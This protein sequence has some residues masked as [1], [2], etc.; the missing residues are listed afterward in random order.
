LNNYFH[1]YDILG[2]DGQIY[3]LEGVQ[4]EDHTSGKATRVSKDGIE[5]DAAEFT[6]SPGKGPKVNQL[7]STSD[8]FRVSQKPLPATATY[9]AAV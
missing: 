9:N 6:I 7:Q 3:N 4:Q 5:I 8:D 1:V 2:A